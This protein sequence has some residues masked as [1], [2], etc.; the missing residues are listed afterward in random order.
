MFGTIKITMLGVLGEIAA[1]E[2]DNPLAK[3]IKLRK[4]YKHN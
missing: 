2:F 3:Y 4:K 1:K